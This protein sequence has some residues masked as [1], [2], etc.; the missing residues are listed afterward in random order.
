MKQDKIN[1]NNNRYKT[2]PHITATA[3]VAVKN[4]Q[5]R[6]NSWLAPTIKKHSRIKNEQY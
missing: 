4:R 3:A 1:K 6:Q 2:V 5:R